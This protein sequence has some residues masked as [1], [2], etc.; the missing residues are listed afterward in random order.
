MNVIGN[1]M[2][3]LQSTLGALLLVC[4]LASAAWTARPTYAADLSNCAD[5]GELKRFEGSSI[6]LCGSY[7]FAEYTLPTGKSISYDSRA[8]KG[9]FE[10]VMNLE[11]HLT[12]NVYAVPMGPSA[13][14]VFR[15]YKADLAAKGYSILFEAK[16]ADI[17]PAMGEFFED[18]GP[19]TQIWGYSPD[20]ARYAAAVKD[21][22]G[23]KT[24][25]ALYIIEYDDGYEPRFHPQKGQVMVRLDAVQIGELT[26]RMVTVSS[27]QISTALST[28]G[29][30]ALYGILFDFNTATLE[31]E[32][33]PTLDAVARYL[34]ENP[35]KN[36]VLTGHTDNVGGLDFNM[37]LSQ[38]RAAA[39]AADLSQR[40]AIQ[41]DRIT[42]KGMG[43]RVPVASNDTEAGRAKNRRVELS[44]H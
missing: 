5:V 33:R 26:N 35:T 13:A 6:V 3:H 31:S 30:I 41:A 27:Q 15:N 44:V 23:A 42:V 25:I 39:V 4:L 8:R 24:Y 16:Q 43:P 32:S 7:E 28:E 9:Q 34:K 37:H 29:H 36:V 18:T 40:C 11:G 22:G 1:T 38:A 10:A 12:Q 17:G 20:E 2:K 21:S 19:G 14:Q